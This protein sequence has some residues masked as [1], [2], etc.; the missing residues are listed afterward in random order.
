M[1]NIFGSIIVFM[2]C[3]TLFFGMIYTV[4]FIGENIL[5]HMPDWLY[6]AIGLSIAGYFIYKI[7]QGTLNT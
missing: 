7:G 1:N 6:Y 5:M 3:A 2:T 4:L